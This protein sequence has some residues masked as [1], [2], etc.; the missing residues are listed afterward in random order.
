MPKN[1][2]AISQTKCSKYDKIVLIDGVEI[3]ALLDSGSDITIM[4]ADEY[5]R[6]GS[7]RF[8]N[9]SISFQGVGRGKNVTLG[10]FQANLTVDENVYPIL[11]RVVSD[12]LLK[13]KLLIG[14]DFLHTID[15]AVKRGKATISPPSESPLECDSDQPEVFR[16]NVVE[17]H[18]ENTVDLS[19]VRDA[20]YRKI[21][22]DLVDNYKPMQTRDVGVKMSIVLSDNEPVYQRARRLAPHDRDE[23]NTQISRWLEDG[24][25]R[26]SVSD[27]ASPVVLVA[28]K[29]GSK[30]LCVDYR[31]LNRK[32]IKDRYPLPLI[33]DQLDKLQGA[34]VFSTFDLKNGFFHVP[35]DDSSQKYMAFIVP[36]G[37]FEFLKMPFG[38][39]NSPA[40]FQKF[41]NAAFKDLIHDGSVL[42]YMDDLIIPSENYESG[43][44]KLKCALEVASETGLLVNWKK[45]AFLQTKI[46]FLGH[47]IESG[48]VHPS[49]K[50]I[51]AVIDFPRPTN[52]RQVQAFLG[53]TGYFR[54][55]VPGYS[56]IARPLT[57]LLKMNV[58]F[59][60][61]EKQNDAFVRLKIILSSQPVL[62]L[63]RINAETEL[64][65]DASKY[66]YG[67]ILLQ[68]DSEDNALHPVY[69]SSGKTTPAEEKYS[70]YE[71]EVL[72]IVKA[73]KKFRIYLL[74]IPFKIVTDCRVF[75]LTMN[76]KDLCVRVARWALYLEE[77]KYTIEH[78]PGKN[79]AHVDALSRNP[80]PKCLLI[81]E[82]REGLIPRLKKAQKN[83]A[84]TNRIRELAKLGQA[85]GYIVRGE[86][87]F[88]E[89]DNDV[90]LVVPKGM[91]SQIIKRA[92]ERGHFSTH[93]TETIVKR[94]YYIPNLRTKV[95]RVVRNCVDCILAEKK[96]G[97]QEGY[98]NPIDKGEIPLD[99]YHIDHLGPLTTTKKS[100]RHILVV[101]DGFSKF[102][103]LYATKSTT[104]A[105]VLVR[106]EKQ[107]A[108]FGNPRRII[109]DRGTAFTSND[110]EDYCRR[111]NIQHVLTTTGVP[112]SNG[113]V[114]RVNRTLI[115]LLTKLSAPK[116]KEWFKYLNAAQLYLNTT[117]HR[118]I[119]MTPFRLLFGSHAR[120]RDD[121][122]IRELIENEWVTVF[123]EARDEIR[124]QAKENIKKIQEENQRSYNKRR[125]IAKTYCTGDLVAIRRTQQ[126]P[127][128]KFAS[129]YFGPYEVT[130]VLRNDRYMVRKVGEHEGPMETTTS[131]DYMKFWIQDE[132][133][134]GSDAEN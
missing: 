1:S 96:Q 73:L 83:D 101:V 86:L 71:L 119:G 53:L 68:R 15:L 61:N 12:D 132:E 64:H 89:D 16:V 59:M 114:E 82:D 99:T 116:P 108:T 130:R 44:K 46:E 38:L 115:P 37:H 36:D 90:K 111:E 98:L 54:K 49:E 58:P 105:E 106:L 79:M 35:V 133:S 87:L 34:R 19:N 50:K 94:D 10:E 97:R 65:T 5:V 55:F 125:K 27:Y 110:F 13:Y 56:L 95:E 32:V 57:N 66:G 118:S 131:V 93:K 18:D 4:R 91:H 104:T 122:D 92:H 28:K 128:L 134:D 7:P 63:Y 45:C 77:F 126:G 62:K 124:I 103:W 48:R 8:E 60:F 75:T 20:Q 113:Q 109:S 26:H 129:K 30:R 85:H 25:V 29:D 31:L 6:L 100:Y 21:I 17:C 112:R 3:E 121:S 81:D 127:G 14:R 42:T 78:R 72:A 40:V 41:I 24:I 88:R 9:K 22:K 107:A 76:K 52:V 47:V 80:L 33:E 74:A 23:V 69:F 123:G 39:C 11:I 84:E 117:P 2:C 120:L 70:S 51:E 67:A 43:L 102:T